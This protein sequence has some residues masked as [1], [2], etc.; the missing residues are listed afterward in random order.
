MAGTVVISVV[1]DVDT[2][3]A[4]ALQAAAASAI[5]D[6]TGED[7][8]L[9]LTEVS[10]LNS[11]GLTALV[12]ATAHAEARREPL[13]I[14]VDSNRPVIRPIELTGL[15]ELLRLYH[16]VEEALAAGNQSQRHES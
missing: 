6:T 12:E 8:V 4:P 13:R 9:D 16:T 14:V 3:T 2:D 5:D 1:G 7:C 15:D 11:A 10:F